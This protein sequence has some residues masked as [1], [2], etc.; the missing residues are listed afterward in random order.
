MKFSFMSFSCPELSWGEILKV[1]IKYG[2]NGIEPRI[3]SGHKHGIEIDTPN[4]VILESKKMAEQSGIEISCIATSC[5]YA[6][7]DMVNEKIDLTK[8]CIEL[9]SKIGSPVIRVFGGKIPEGV[10]REKSFD[11][12]VKSLI[13]L[14]EFAD[15]SD[16]KICMETHDSWCD[17][18]L[19]VNVM[20]NV[21]HHSVAVNWDIMHPVLRAGNT[22]DKAFEILKPWIQHVHVHDGSFKEE[23]RKLILKPIGTGAVDH[24][25]AI[26]LLKEMGYKGFVSGE[27]IKWESYDIHL[28]REIETL[29]QYF[30]L[31][32]FPQ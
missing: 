24:K 15:G 16:V 11:L 23:K 2:Y 20:K 32:S 5:K 7:P 10:T 26:K 29:K 12:I 6:D 31:I 27:W 4:S 25:T 13:K 30:G 17:T 1:A 19:V 28:P 8:R 9:A 3:D 22:M 14:A 18:E 21:N